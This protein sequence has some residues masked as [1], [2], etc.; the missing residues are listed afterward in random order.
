MLDLDLLVKPLSGDDPCGRDLDLDGDLDYLNFF[1][2]AESLLPKSYFEVTDSEGNKKRFDPSVLDLKAELEKA[3]PLL[4]RTRDLRLIV[5]LAKIAILA[6][7]LTG[8]I[9][10]LQAIA[11]LLD[12]YWDQV[13]PRPEGGELAL[14][15]YAIEALDAVPTVIMPLQF[16]PLLSSRR[17]GV[18]SYRT[19]Q[20]AKGELQPREDDVVL[21]RAA[22]DQV[23]DTADLDQ[24]K[25]AA[26]KAST[27]IGALGQIN[28][29]WSDKTDSAT[30]LSWERLATV[31]EGIDRLLAD[32]VRRRDPT[33][34]A[35]TGADA[36][37]KLAGEA[38]GPHATPGIG[39]VTSIADV[40]AALAGV[41]SYFRHSEPSSP[42]LL[43][44][45][46]AQQM[47]GKSFVDALRIL[48]P[49]HVE[50]AAINIGRDRFFDLPV[51]RMAGLLGDGSGPEPISSEAD[52]VVV[53]QR[54]QALALL[55]QVGA[56]YRAVEP[57][58]P[59][60]Y[61]TDRARE[62]AQRDFLSLLRDV[63]P[64]GALRK[65]DNQG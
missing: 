31:A 49:S 57:S 14:R 64:D 27:L 1:A 44:V 8:F 34:A 41:A 38:G 23:V 35:T 11:A 2:S 46:Q 40:A 65:I 47:L 33:A 50:A 32:M 51:E 61:L 53:T 48:V 16:Q 9:T 58:S 37:A 15:Q 3:K 26:A 24:L 20:I 30:M 5:F 21:D 17:Y 13:H 52:G 45:L 55:E 59:V 18:I 10:S 54:S 25:D 62:L 6:R 12:R 4:A 56:F 60:P 42:A 22:L 28:R 39:T 36:D 43:L 63:L 19:C 7:D 29:I